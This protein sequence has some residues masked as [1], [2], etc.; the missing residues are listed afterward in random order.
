MNFLLLILVMLLSF[1]AQMYLQSTFGRFS[2]IRNGRD[3]TG[4]EVARDILDRNGLQNVRVEPVAGMLTDHY[5][6]IHKVVRLSE[7][8]YN[9]PSL[10]ALAVAAH[11]VGHALQDKNAYAPLIVR[12]RLAPVL[13]A[14]AN[15]GQLALFI[16]IFMLAS[17]FGQTMLLIGI[18]GL[19]A[20]VV[21]HLV[22]LPVEFD[23]SNRALKILETN[24]YLT[25]EEN[26]GA[27][28]VL[29]AAALT[30]VAAAIA[31]LATL[32][33]YLGFLRRDE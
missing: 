29:T 22:T 1:G 6:P 4:A 2:R 30:Y 16:G 12:A 25:R 3:L 18:I 19:A 27:K 15:L 13:G 26:Q 5:D 32:L 23:A 17:S 11:E 33:Y 9:Q 31:A 21:F 8:N 7:V 10:A 20:A 28:S 14:A 24:G